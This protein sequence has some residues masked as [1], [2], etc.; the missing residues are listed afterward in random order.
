M[1][2]NTRLPWPLLP[3]R[4]SRHLGNAWSL[5][6]PPQMVLDVPKFRWSCLGLGVVKG[7]GAMVTYMLDDDPLDAP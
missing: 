1:Q 2:R 5:P 7:K 3:R 6:P 4:L